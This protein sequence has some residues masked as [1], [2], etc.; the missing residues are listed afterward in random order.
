[1]GGIVM[2]DQNVLA[3]RRQ[4]GLSRKQFCEALEI[5]YRTVQAWELGVRRCPAYTFAMMAKLLELSD[6]FGGLD[7]FRCGSGK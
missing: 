1:M 4:Y 6:R 2:G 5:P 3:L 7:A